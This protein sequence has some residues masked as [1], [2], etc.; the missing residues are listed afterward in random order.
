MA[1]S[2]VKQVFGGTDKRKRD[3]TKRQ[4]LW[5]VAMGAKLSKSGGRG[6]RIPPKGLEGWLIRNTDGYPGTSGH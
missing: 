4:I 1:W 5:K 6:N 3:D 2:G